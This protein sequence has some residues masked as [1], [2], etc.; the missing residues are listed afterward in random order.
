[1][2]TTSFKISG[3]DFQDNDCS[4]HRS[5]LFSINYCKAEM[6]CLKHILKNQK[7]KVMKCLTVLVQQCLFIHNNIAAA[8]L[9]RWP[10]QRLRWQEVARDKQDAIQRYRA[11]M[12]RKK[13]RTLQ[14][15][16]TTTGHRTTVIM[17]RV[18][19]LVIV[20]YHA[21]I[22]KLRNVFSPHTTYFLKNKTK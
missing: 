12:T 8:Y 20:R 14:E 21:S 1:M 2:R 15:R 5:L 19:L 10:H 13:I 9:Q 18:N 4:T 7:R 22:S 16:S 6:L 3:V 11:K 17:K